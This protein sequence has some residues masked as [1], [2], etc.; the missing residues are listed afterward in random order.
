MSSTASPLAKE[1]KNENERLIKLLCFILLFSVMNVTMFNIALPDIA[2][3]FALLPSQASW[4]VTGYAIMYAV[5]SLTY[6]KLADRY[7]LKL[8]LTIGLSLFAAGSLLGF[9]APYYWLLVVAR[10]LQ[11]AG[12]AAIPALA[13]LIPL[14]FFPV[15]DRGRVLGIIASAIAFAS[16][17]GPIVGGFVSGFLNWRFLFLI[18]AGTLITLPLFRRWLPVEET[19][20]GSMD[21]P[22]A[23]LLSGTVALLMLSITTLKLWFL[24]GGLVLLAL[25]IVRI[26]SAAHPFIQP[27][28]LKI[29]QYRSA[30]L[31]AFL[32]F[33]AS[34]GI[35]FA[36]P[37]LLSHVTNLP[38]TVIGLAM[39]PGALSAAL[40]GRYGGRMADAR[41]SVTVIGFGLLLVLVGL[42]ALSTF[43]SY[44]AWVIAVCLI[45]GNVGQSFFQASMTKLVSTTLPAGQTG[46]GMGIFTLTNFLAGAVSGAVVSK[47]I[48][49]TADS[50]AFNPFAMAGA[51]A[52][53]SNVFLG[54]A[55]VTLL[56]LALVYAV[57]GR[58]NAK[59]AGV[60]PQAGEGR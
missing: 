33:G 20:P 6:G 14:R 5:G 1:G 40:L 11:S 56:N 54:L 22:G 8:L 21:L 10:L 44:P 13:M 32:T 49:K 23:A 3:E 59:A 42:L 18:S 30:L 4:V 36:A 9:I 55:V 25:F 52:V 15:G 43:S 48:D 27:A 34:F 38:T 16:G 29:V 24:L 12:A 37:Q 39:F 50:S 47:L 45:F 58:R 7:P 35:M 41:G 60:A 53:Y 26:R 31:S 17:V 57:F 46:I 2:R 28:L 51:G 19:R